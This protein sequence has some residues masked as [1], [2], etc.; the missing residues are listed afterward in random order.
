MAGRLGGGQA[1]ERSWVYEPNGAVRCVFPGQNRRAARERNV[2]SYSGCDVRCRAIDLAAAGIVVIERV[3]QDLRAG[4]GPENSKLPGVVHD[5]SAH[6]WACN[7]R[8]LAFSRALCSP[9][10]RIAG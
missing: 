6:R 10:E 4:G 7:G 3:V 2:T 8:R 5:E 9:V 1:G